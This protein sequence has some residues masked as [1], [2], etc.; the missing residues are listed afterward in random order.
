MI[1]FCLVKKYERK[2]KTDL[3]KLIIYSNDDMF[4][5]HGAIRYY[6]MVFKIMGFFYVN[7]HCKEADAERR[8]C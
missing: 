7:H 1:S 5:L 4:R 6:K 2:R 8:R 3:L